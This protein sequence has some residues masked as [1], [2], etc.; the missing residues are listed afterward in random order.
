MVHRRMRCLQRHW[1]TLG[2]VSVLLLGCNPQN[3]K[4]DEEVEGP[5]TG[6]MEAQA[7]GS[8]TPPSVRPPLP[9]NAPDWKP[10]QEWHWS[11]GYALK[12]EK[13][14]GDITTFRRLDV[15]GQWQ[16]RDGLFLVESQSATRHR[17][18]IYRTDNPKTLFPLA[19]G[20]SRVFRREYLSNG[21]LRVHRTS[22]TV[23]G[24]EKIRVPAGE[25]DCWILMRRTRS[26]VSDWLGYE[27]WWYSPELQ[28]YAR[29]EYQYG[30]DVTGSRVL[31][32]YVN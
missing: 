32:S 23:E 16:K 12:V 18:T 27:R 26:L 19:E 20:K 30:P 6:H 28:H 4:P 15:P 7:V 8:A 10:G 2:L 29:L 17:K 24:R 25:F 5:V 11:D 21:E 9:A 22:W 14:A 13:R 3:T 1:W 31:M